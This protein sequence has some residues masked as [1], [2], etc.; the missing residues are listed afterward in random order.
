LNHFRDFGLPSGVEIL[1]HCDAPPGS[2]LG[3]SSTMVATLVGVMADW[4]RRPMTPYEVAE[5]TYR[6][7]RIDL[8]IS[9]G[10]DQY[11]ATFGVFNFMEFHADYAVVNPL[12]LR[13]ATVNEL[14]YALL[15]CY[16][17]ETRLS[18]HIVDKQVRAYKQRVPEVLARSTR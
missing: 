8:G 10:Q 4:C 16:T 3:S 5:L 15:L 14:E 12:R 11:A 17:G 2:G 18:G 13:R 9:G 7:E 6:I 1:V